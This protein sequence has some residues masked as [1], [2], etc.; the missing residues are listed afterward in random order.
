MKFLARIHAQGAGQRRHNRANIE[1]FTR[2]SNFKRNFLIEQDRCK[3]RSII[4]IF[5]SKSRN[6]YSQISL[7][8]RYRAY[9]FRSFLNLICHFSSIIDSYG[10]FQLLW[11][12]KTWLKFCLWAKIEDT[13]KTQSALPIDLH[14]LSN[15]LVSRKNDEFRIVNEMS[16]ML[17]GGCDWQEGEIGFAVGIIR[18]ETRWLHH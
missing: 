2:P 18:A 1:L 10:V 11:R 13:E 5:L 12:D 16:N 7:S 14:L 3:S 9:F 17:R 15:G 8:L 4:K 6:M